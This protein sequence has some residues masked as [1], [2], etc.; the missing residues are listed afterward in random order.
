MSRF[1]DLLKPGH[2]STPKDDQDRA[3]AGLAV[4][5][6]QS[7]LL[8]WKKRDEAP[9][10]AK[11]LLLAVAPYSQYDLALLDLIDQRPGAAPAVQVY[12]ANVQDYD[13]VDA[14]AADFPGAPP[15]PQTPLAA[16]WGAGSEKQVAWGKKARDLAADALGL[17]AED[18]SARIK[19]DAPRYG[20]SIS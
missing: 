7:N 18:V 17:S 16:L 11:C 9:R 2:G 15:S 20:A 5:V 19:A 13:S 6:E 10:P 1:L 14:L 8:W 3:S 12:V 4:A